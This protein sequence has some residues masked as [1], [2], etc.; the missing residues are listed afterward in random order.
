MSH[1]RLA[2]SIAVLVVTPHGGFTAS[3][4]SIE[5]LG[6]AY[7]GVVWR[8]LAARQTAVAALAPPS[9]TV[10]P[11]P[12]VP[13]VAAVPK[14][15]FYIRIGFGI[16]PATSASLSSRFGPTIGFGYR[17][18]IDSW[19]FDVSVL[20]A[21]GWTRGDSYTA[22]VLSFGRIAAHRLIRRDRARRST[23]V[24]HQLWRGRG[25]SSNP[26]YGNSANSFGLQAEA[27]VG[28]ELMRDKPVRLFFEGWATLPLYPVPLYMYSPTGGGSMTER[29][30]AP[31]INL[32]AGLG[33]IDHGGIAAKPSSGTGQ[34]NTRDG[35]DLSLL[36]PP[37]AAGVFAIPASHR[38]QVA[39]VEHGRST[40][41]CDHARW[42]CGLGG[43]AHVGGSREGIDESKVRTSTKDRIVAT[44]LQPFGSGFL[45]YGGASLRLI[46]GASGGSRLRFQARVWHSLPR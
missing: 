44:T 38:K 1:V 26:M 20:N 35:N 32:S 23:P 18:A 19:L 28:Y 22:N 2:T 16:A 39:T 13:L 33:F 45:T 12:D 43:S 7:E 36:E 25:N 41:A 42:G 37:C 4:G 46:D 24:E 15:V 40:V 10:A 27:V 11:P 29:Y 31:T 6:G 5:G 21:H 14:G 3:A 17:R 30:W 8:A 9:A 34:R